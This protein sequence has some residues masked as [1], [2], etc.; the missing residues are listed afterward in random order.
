MWVAYAKE[1]LNFMSPLLQWMS[2][3]LVWISGT[4]WIPGGI[5]VRVGAL[6]DLMMTGPSCMT[7]L[8]EATTIEGARIAL[9]WLKASHPVISTWQVATSVPKDC[10]LADFFEEVKGFA[11]LMATDCDLDVNI[12]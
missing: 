4:M 1:T 10:Q 6:V 9:A 3:A 11:K 7:V 12:E 8:L 2:Q 5:D